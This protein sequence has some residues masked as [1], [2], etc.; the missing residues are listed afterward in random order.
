MSEFGQEIT[1]TGGM[2]RAVMPQLQAFQFY[3]M[4]SHFWPITGT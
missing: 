1:F 4:Y 3:K 2:G